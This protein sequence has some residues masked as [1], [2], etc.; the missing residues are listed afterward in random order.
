M[1]D[2][3]CARCG[4]VAVTGKYQA[5]STDATKN[6]KH[7]ELRALIHTCN[8]CT[9][10]RSRPELHKNKV[11]KKYE[12]QFLN[13]L[14]EDFVIGKYFHVQLN[15]SNESDNKQYDA[16][17]SNNKNH[18]NPTI[19][20][21]EIDEK[22]HYNDPIYFTRDRAKERNF[23]EVNKNRRAYVFRIRVSEDS[24]DK[25][26][27]KED[28]KCFV[29]DPKKFDSNML[30]SITHIK[31][32]LLGQGKFKNVDRTY[33]DFSNYDGVI[34]YPFTS[35]VDSKQQKK[36]QTQSSS[37]WQDKEIRQ[38]TAGVNRLVV[39][40][41]KPG[42]CKSHGCKNSTWQ[43]DYCDKCSKKHIEEPE[44]S[45]SKS[46]TKQRCSQKVG[47][48]QCTKETTSASGLCDKHT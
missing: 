10:P 48:G 9:S 12:H 20:N 43:T 16:W 8:R 17:I 38:I 7:G 47:R 41:V 28:G 26:V 42:S 18:E 3:L 2:K 11:F 35:V 6:N 46:R 34:S 31:K 23:F 45:S 4:K 40:D 27:W 30:N 24:A 37:G 13:L 36:E 22:G 19:I 32:L 15:Q 29:K 25:C 33:I 44:K 39:N 1:S 5:L 14:L 21:I